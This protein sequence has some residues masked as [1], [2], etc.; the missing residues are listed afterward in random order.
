MLSGLALCIS[1]LFII[2]AFEWRI[3][4]Q[5][6]VVAINAAE[7]SFENLM[8]IPQT[9]QMQPPPPQIQSPQVIE[10][11]DEE[12]VE[13]IRVDLDIEMTE[14][15]KIEEV[16]FDNTAEVIPEEKADEI[17]TI[18]E[19]Q[20]S[21]HGGLQAFY[22]YVGENLQYPAQARRMGIEGRVFVQF[23]VEKDGSLTDIQA[24]KGIGGGCD[25]EAIRVL[26]EAP[27]W[28]PGKQRGRPVRVRMVLPIMFRLVA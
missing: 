23:V 14:D 27:K 3:S 4:D 16:V 5:G 10:V 13:E 28:K 26:S 11:A 19:E 25:Q 2:G 24:V 8:E 1:V 20:P 9:E 18:V 22:K 15:T 7:E 17:F 21:P 12:I 6:S